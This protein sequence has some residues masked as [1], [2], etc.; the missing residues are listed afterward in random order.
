[1][2]KPY[3]AS[4]TVNEI[5]QLIN[6]YYTFTQGGDLVGFVTFKGTR[7]NQKEIPIENC[8]S[9]EQ[10]EYF[11]LCGYLEYSNNR[12]S[13]WQGIKIYAPKLGGNGA[14]HRKLAIN[15]LKSIAKDIESAR[16]SRNRI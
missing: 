6:N 11:S 16:I 13:D 5:L 10:L 8:L 3:L 15:K 4:L 9:K 1:M 12:I 7:F 14:E 2:T